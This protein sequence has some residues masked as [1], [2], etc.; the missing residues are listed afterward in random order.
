MRA[1]SAAWP[2]L[3]GSYSTAARSEARLTAAVCTPS[4]FFR[5]RSTVATQLA[6]VMPVMGNVMVLVAIL[7]FLAYRISVIRSDHAAHGMFRRKDIMNALRVTLSAN[8]IARFNGQ[9]RARRVYRPFN[10]EL[11]SVTN[12]C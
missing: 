8:A 11:E 2:S 9:D 10:P 1:I 6:Q 7:N 4:S 3:A 5:L 12:N